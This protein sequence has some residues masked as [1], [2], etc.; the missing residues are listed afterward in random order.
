MDTFKVGEYFVYVPPFS[1]KAQDKVFRCVGKTAK[2]SV[3]GWNIL[4]GE[5]KLASEYCYPLVTPPPSLLEDGA[6]EYEDYI[7]GRNILDDLAGKG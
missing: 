4:A 2:G 1:S 3:V 7:A 6:Q 5:M